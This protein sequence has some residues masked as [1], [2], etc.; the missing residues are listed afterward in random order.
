MIKSCFLVVLLF[1]VL[2]RIKGL[3]S[4]TFWHDELWTAGYWAQAESLTQVW[5]HLFLPY[6]ANLPLY[7]FFI[8]I[9]AKIFGSGELFLKLPS[10]IASVLAIPLIF[11]LGRKLYGDLEGLIASVLLC[12]LSIP[13]YVSQEAR[14]YS[15]LL[16]LCL[17]NLLARI[18]QK[19]KG[20]LLSGVL[21][22]WLHYFGIIFL[23]LQGLMDLISQRKQAKSYLVF[24]LAL[25]PLWQLIFFQLTHGPTLWAESIGVILQDISLWLFLTDYPWLSGLF[26]GILML[27]IFI[28]FKK[29]LKSRQLSYLVLAPIVITLSIHLLVRPSFEERYLII[30]LGPAFLL[31]ARALALFYHRYKNFGWIPLV[32][33][34]PLAYGAWQLDVPEINPLPKIKNA[35]NYIE[36]S[37]VCQKKLLVPNEQYKRLWSYYLPEY[38]TIKFINRAETRANDSF[39]YLGDSESEQDGEVQQNIE[40]DASVITRIAR[41]ESVL[42]CYKTM[43]Q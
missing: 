37:D 34:A 20:W 3:T 2:L 27:M 42:I 43:R 29:D 30:V 18:M 16:T 15:F 9:W 24:L 21:L 31:V 28:A 14:G 33:C 8:F 35:L 1:S 13:L 6:E 26:S 4:L 5:Q 39:W 7:P 38:P 41:G 40:Q 10:F 12:F 19:K 17:A 25:L 32:L 22:C 11:Q 23:G 36:K